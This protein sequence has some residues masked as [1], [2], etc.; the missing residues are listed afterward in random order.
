M[1]HRRIFEFRQSHDPSEPPWL[2]EIEQTTESGCNSS[3]PDHRAEPAWLVVEKIRDFLRSEIL[4]L[5]SGRFRAPAVVRNRLVVLTVLLDPTISRSFAQEARGL[6]CTKAQ[7]SKTA[8][9]FTR[10]FGL[11]PLPTNGGRARK[12]IAAAA[13]VRAQR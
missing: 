1:T 6:G 11:K 7:L 5:A 2:D 9:M 4:C 10:K 12:K 8:R 3:P 13:P